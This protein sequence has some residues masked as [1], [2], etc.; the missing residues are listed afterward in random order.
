MKS[1]FDP[2]IEMILT[3]LDKQISKTRESLKQGPSISVISPKFFIQ[4]ILAD[5]TRHYQGI[6]L[7]GGFARSPYVRR[8]VMDWC[9]AG[10]ALHIPDMP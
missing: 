5:S 6:I 8:R 9:P 4:D 2:V 7:T 1:L 10:I 3:V